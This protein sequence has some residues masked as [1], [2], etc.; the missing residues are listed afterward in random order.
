MINDGIKYPALYF[1]HD[2]KNL[3]LPLITILQYDMSLS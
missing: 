3:Y 2:S 1:M